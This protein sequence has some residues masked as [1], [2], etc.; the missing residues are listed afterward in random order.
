[1]VHVV[2]ATGS[3]GSQNIQSYISLFSSTPG[4]L[5]DIVENLEGEEFSCGNKTLDLATFS[6][7]YGCLSYQNTE[8][9]WSK[10]E[11]PILKIKSDKKDDIRKTRV[12]LDTK[13]SHRWVLAINTEYISDFSF[14]GDVVIQ[15]SYSL[16]VVV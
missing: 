11:I 13:L 8:E 10:S 2:E 15:N 4:K 9:G 7:A 3:N 5:T 16:L 1:M 12:L 6:V 14:A